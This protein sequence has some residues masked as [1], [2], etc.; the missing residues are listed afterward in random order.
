MGKVKGYIKGGRG[1]GRRGRL[2]KQPQFINSNAL[3]LPKIANLQ[4]E[5]SYTAR[6]DCQRKRVLVLK[7]NDNFI[8]EDNNQSKSRIHAV[9]AG[10][11]KYSLALNFSP[12][13]ICLKGA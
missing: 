8:K 13:I 5:P 11:M 1:L 7:P 10:R 9:S 4:N 6:K 12:Q 2:D 3:A